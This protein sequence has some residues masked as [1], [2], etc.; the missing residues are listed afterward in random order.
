[1]DEQVNTGTGRLLKRGKR[2]L[3]HISE[4]LVSTAAC[5]GESCQG[6]SLNQCG[7][8]TNGFLQMVSVK[9]VCCGWQGTCHS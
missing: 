9:A 1:M 2:V 4:A 3:G 7:T 5:V 6:S 8:Y